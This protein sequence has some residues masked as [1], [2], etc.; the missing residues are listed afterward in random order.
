MEIL[1]ILHSM[2]L[3]FFAALSSGRWL[4][5][6]VYEVLNITM[7]IHKRHCTRVQEIN[8]SRNGHATHV[9]YNNTQ[10]VVFDDNKDTSIVAM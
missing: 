9:M 7:Y 10:S 1:V 8:K 4:E 5:M 2:L 6:H 3:M